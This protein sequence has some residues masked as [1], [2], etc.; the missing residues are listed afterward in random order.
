MVN[1]S[2]LCHK[3]EYQEYQDVS[4]PNVDLSKVP[5][6]IA[7]LPECEAFQEPWKKAIEDLPVMQ[8]NRIYGIPGINTQMTAAL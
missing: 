6:A 8:T 4:R 2:G 3:V 5:V 7:H 1:R